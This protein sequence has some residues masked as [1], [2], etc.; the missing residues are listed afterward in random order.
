MPNRES[1][2]DMCNIHPPAHVLQ[3]LQAKQPQGPKQVR[4]PPR[5]DVSFWYT[6]GS[7]ADNNDSNNGNN[8][9]NDLGPVA[10]LLGLTRTRTCGKVRPQ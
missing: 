1:V 10:P 7:R 8:G 2:H 3:A 6:S 4:N 9:N 5:E